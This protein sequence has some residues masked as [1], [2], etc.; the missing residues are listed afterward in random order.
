MEILHLYCLYDSLYRFNYFFHVPMSIANI[1]VILGAMLQ[2]KQ[3]PGFNVDFAVDDST[4]EMEF[5]IC[6]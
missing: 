6:A 5:S 4:L 2:E 1:A 3:K